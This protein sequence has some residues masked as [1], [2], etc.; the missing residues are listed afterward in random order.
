[1]KDGGGE[2]KGG[3]E[4]ER[5]ERGREGGRV[6]GMDGRREGGKEGGIEEGRGGKKEMHT[7]SIY[8]Q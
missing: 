3:R 5:G 6:G 2:V 7:K 4:W 8:R 1:M